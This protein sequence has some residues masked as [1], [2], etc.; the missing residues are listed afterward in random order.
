VDDRFRRSMSVSMPALRTISALP[1]T[2]ILVVALAACTSV[3]PSP[4]PTPPVTGGASAGSSPAAST[5]SSATTEP[6]G[7]SAPAEATASG[8]V[9]TDV[10]W[11]PGGLEGPSY[12]PGTCHFGHDGQWVLPDPHCT[13]GAIDRAVTQETLAETICRPGGYTR[14]VRPPVSLTRPA[15]LAA[16]RAYS[17]PG[18]P[19]AYEFDH[20]VPLSLGG[21]SDTRNLWPEPN[22]GSPADFDP[23]DP[24]GINAKDGVE[25]ALHAA[26][27]AG[28]VSL[29]AA[30]SAIARDWAT[31]LS[32]L[33]LAP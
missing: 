22:Q 31:A 11:G 2:V 23:S 1:V 17:A 6:S 9:V 24:Y 20:L 28:R 27:C 33:G 5:E 19:S 12:E 3:S 4:P 25:D 15:K 30:Q 16:M 8:L 26:V 14:S 10:G 29:A 13:P 21:S 7:N 32:T 18:P